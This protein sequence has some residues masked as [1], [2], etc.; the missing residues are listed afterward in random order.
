MTS[1]RYRLYSVGKPLS[2]LC[3]CL[4]IIFAVNFNIGGL[5]REVCYGYTSYRQKSEWKVNPNKDNGFSIKKKKKKKEKINN[6]PLVV[7]R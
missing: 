2:K 6:Y 7:C 4:V 3:Q 1:T 5:G